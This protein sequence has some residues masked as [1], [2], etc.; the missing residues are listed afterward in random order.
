MRNL[1]NTKFYSEEEVFDL[2][3]LYKA[4]YVEDGRMSR[5]QG[6]AVQYYMSQFMYCPST[7]I[8]HVFDRKPWHVNQTITRMNEAASESR[9]PV[10]MNESYRF[11]IEDIDDLAREVFGSKNK[12]LCMVL[13]QKERA[14]LLWSAQK[15][16]GWFDDSSNSADQEEVVDELLKTIGL[17]PGGWMRD[18]IM[19]NYIVD[20][21]G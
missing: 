6:A 4:N 12:E 19:E 15:E 7:L 2:I 18:I 11:F 10:T 14:W 9:V 17:P 21:H 5:A 3:S 13:D 16:C 20:Y 8:A 1:N